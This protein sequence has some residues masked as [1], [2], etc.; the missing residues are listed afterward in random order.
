MSQHWHAL[1]VCVCL[2]V[3]VC[4]C[5]CVCVYVCLCVYVCVCV[6]VR[7]RV[8][9]RSC[10]FV[11]CNNYSAEIQ[12]HGSNELSPNVTQRPM[13]RTSGGK[14]FQV[15][16]ELLFNSSQN[17]KHANSSGPDCSRDQ[18]VRSPSARMASESGP[19]LSCRSVCVCVCVCVCG[20]CVRVME[21]FNCSSEGAFDPQLKRSFQSNVF[22]LQLFE[23][24]LPWNANC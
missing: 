16:C 13:I 1:C 15:R 4:V 18:L 12:L 10:V 20:V 9:V 2:C 17:I 24:R 3:S 14:K 6:C 11:C 7:V 8:T 21:L 5:L 23:E 22:Q 19:D